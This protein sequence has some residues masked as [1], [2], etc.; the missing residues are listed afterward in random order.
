MHHIPNVDSNLQFDSS[1]GR[2]VVITLGQG[3]L[4]FDGA[5]G[6]FQRAIE[7]DQESVTDC[8]NLGAIEARENFAEQLAMF[9]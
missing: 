5:L 4:N 1:L 3:A 6:R 9:F 2:H 7:L 8:F